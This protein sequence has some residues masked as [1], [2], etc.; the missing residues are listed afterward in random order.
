MD[1]RRLC[2]ERQ[3]RSGL[4][5]VVELTRYGQKA[6]E[7]DATIEAN[8]LTLL[9]CYR[10]P[11]GEVQSVRCPVQV[12][13]SKCHYGGQR[14]WFRCPREGCGR[15][16]AILY[17]DVTFA[18]R[19]CHRLTY[20]SQQASV[21]DRSL[22]RAQAIRQQLGGTANMYDPFPEKPKGMHWQTYQTLRRT[23]DDANAESWPGWFRRHVK[24]SG[25]GRRP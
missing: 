5:F 17:G 4:S 8:Q 11:T 7:I 21:S 2:R 14:V 9:Y 24:Q 19:R 12:E 1:V 15:R 25:R 10:H 3:L 6:A 22:A 20:R 23:H 13:R 18:C 16:V